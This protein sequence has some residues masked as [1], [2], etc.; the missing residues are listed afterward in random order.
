M[1][2]IN[3]MTTQKPQILL[4]VADDLLKRIDDYRFDNRIV[5]RSETIRQLIEAGLVASKTK[6]KKK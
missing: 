2:Y 3:A 5:S 4:T 6:G 1:K